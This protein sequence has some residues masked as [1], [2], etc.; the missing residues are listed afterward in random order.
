MENVWFKS[1]KNFWINVQSIL[2]LEY[3]VENKYVKKIIFI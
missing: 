1:K 2:L 3:V